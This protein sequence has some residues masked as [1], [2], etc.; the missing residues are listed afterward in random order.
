MSGRRGALPWCEARHHGDIMTAEYEWDDH[1]LTEARNITLGTSSK[2]R[3]LVIGHTER[4]DA[5]RIISARVATKWE[6]SRYEPG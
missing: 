5:I 1:S 2:G 4:G 6:R 3:T